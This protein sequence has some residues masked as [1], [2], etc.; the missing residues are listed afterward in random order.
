MVPASTVSSDANVPHPSAWRKWAFIVCS[1]WARSGGAPQRRGKNA[2]VVSDE[3]VLVVKAHE[4]HGQPS[5]R[6]RKDRLEVGDRKIG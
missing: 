3:E 2:E 1:A 4:G 5:G 6:P